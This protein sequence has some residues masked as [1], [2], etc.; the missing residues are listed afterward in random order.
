[1]QTIP[2][3]TLYLCKNVDLDPNYNYTID[4]D[5][6]TAQANYFDSKIATEFEINEGYSY[7][8]DS[9]T[10]KVQANIDDLLGINYLFYN[11]GNK[12]YYAFILDKKY[13]SDT[14]TA[15][16]FKIDVMQSFMYDYQLK[17]SFIDRQHEDRFNL[18]NNVLTPIYSKTDENIDL[19][20]VYKVIESNV[21]KND[22]RATT[23][24][25]VNIAWY[26]IVCSDKLLQNETITNMYGVHSGYY[27]YFLPVVIGNNGGYHFTFSGAELETD[28]T[29]I[30]KSPK[31]LAVFLSKYT[32]FSVSYSLVGTDRI[33]VNLNGSEWSSLLV[34]TTT[35]YRVISAGS[36]KVSQPREFFSRNIFTESVPSIND[37]KQMKYETKLLTSPYCKL[38]VRANEDKAEFAIEEFTN[39]IKL[40]MGFDY[41]YNNKMLIKPKDYLGGNL[42]NVVIST[43]NNEMALLNDAW[44]NYEA[45]N[46]A[47]LRS[48]ILSSGALASAGV[49]FGVATGG[50]GLALAGGAILSQASQ[51]TNE[52]IKRHNIQETPDSLKKA[53][54]SIVVDRLIK[55]NNMLVELHEIDN[56][57]KVRV[58]NYLYH[59]GYKCNNFITPNLRS[60]YY[61]N[62]IKT[63]GANIETNID[64]SY[65]NELVQIFDNGITIWHYRDSTTFKG[66]NNYEYENVET[67]LLED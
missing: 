35:G 58:Y 2:N 49:I 56:D 33:E 32:P 55:D 53:M 65:K 12:R 20:K 62:Y 48:G 66:V 16:T 9:Q 44:R 3:S 63:I 24:Q 60:R 43:N 14:C 4:F 51:I 13:V 26:T 54:G 34:G 18:V 40:S 59:Y 22:N 52:I 30:T 45:Q 23:L 64:A 19:G 31:T 61:F 1:M 5:N 15:I 57:H 10:L 38:I 21:I 37:L 42:D 46:K 28:I 50:V 47:S 6:I 27:I 17:E 41:S 8:R 29:E 39:N 7:I 11:N 25:N 67:N 36:L